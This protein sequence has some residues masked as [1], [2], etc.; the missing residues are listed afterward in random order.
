MERNEGE[1]RILKRRMDFVPAVFMQVERVSKF[2]REMNQYN[3]KDIKKLER[4]IADL[5]ADLKYHIQQKAKGRM[6]NLIQLN[7]RINGLDIFKSPD[8]YVDLLIKKKEQLIILS[9]F[10]GLIPDYVSGMATHER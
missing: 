1:R 8:K 4:L 5:E 9:G 7:K 3:A 10:S 6:G 2:I